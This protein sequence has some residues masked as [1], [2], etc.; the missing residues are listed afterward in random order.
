MLFIPPPFASRQP[1]FILISSSRISSPKVKLFFIRRLHSSIRCSTSIVFIL[2]FEIRIHTD[3]SRIPSSFP[4]P[5][6]HL[7]ISSFEVA[8]RTTIILSNVSRIQLNLLATYFISIPSPRRPSIDIDSILRYRNEEKFDTTC[9]PVVSKCGA[10][11]IPNSSTRL[12]Y[13]YIFPRVYNVQ[14]WYANSQ[15]DSRH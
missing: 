12:T 7:K 8:T 4:F 15:S 5:P 1:Y 13:L 6:F 2:E 9:S 3:L 14:I 10:I 11:I